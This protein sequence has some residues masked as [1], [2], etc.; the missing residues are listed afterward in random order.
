MIEDKLHSKPLVSVIVLDLDGQRFWSELWAALA[1]QTFR[2]FELVVVENGARLDLPEELNGRPITRL[3][4]RGNLG[5]AGGC[6]WG[7]SRAKGKWLAFLNNDAVPEP[8]WLE[9][10]VS[11]MRGNPEAGAVC[12]KV[13]FYDRYVEVEVEAPVFRPCDFDASPD[14]RSLGV[15]VRLA[16]TQVSLYSRENAYR[17]EDD[18]WV[19]TQDI[20]K[21]R[22]PVCGS[23]KLQ[24]E[25][26]SH[27]AQVG[28]TAVFRCAGREE[29]R[30][31]LTG[32]GQTV[33][34]DV[35][36]EATFDV[37]HN[38]G[39][40]FDKDWNLVELG[41]YERDGSQFSEETEIEMG[42]AC[43]M[44]LRRSALEEEPFENEFFAYFEDSDLCY[45]LRRSAW[46]IQFQPKSIV[47]HHGS[48]TSKIKS[49]FL[50]FQVIRNKLWMI[51]KHAPWRVVARAFF[52]DLWETDKYAPYLNE[53]FSIRRLKREAWMG[54]LSRLWKRLTQD[55]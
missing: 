2:D 14:D 21:F 22:F 30:I 4:G 8:S 19:W 31:K 16:N 10:L 32:E 40:H 52:R 15:K 7:A 45:R 43:S 46:K 9:E 47:R 5:F 28:R 39:S 20:S 54:F 18:A 53:E 26:S 35:P 3:G 42:S 1:K 6:N 55:F 23:G 37:I 11:T 34:F 49:P 51:A 13:L 29:K 50:I 25:L 24:I 17:P 33:R 12:S 44:L 48:A 38:A 41:L 36:P 27:S